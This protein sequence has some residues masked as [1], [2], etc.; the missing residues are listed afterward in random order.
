MLVQPSTLLCCRARAQFAATQDTERQKLLLQCVR[1]SFR[2]FF[3]FNAPGVTPVRV[4]AARDATGDDGGPRQRPLPPLPLTGTPRRPLHCAT[5]RALPFRAATHQPRSMNL[6]RW[7]SATLWS[8]WLTRDVVRRRV[9]ALPPAQLM[10]SQLEAWMDAFHVFLTLPDL[11]ALAEKDKDK[12]S[13]VDAVRCAV[14]HNINL[15]RP[16]LPPPDQLP[17]LRSLLR[18]RGVAGGR[19]G[20]CACRC[21]GVS[22]LWCCVWCLDVLP[23]AQYMEQSEE[24]FAKYLKTFV[25]AVWGL[26]LKL[27]PA[28]GQVRT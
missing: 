3:S 25:T 27:S 13:V 14:C 8:A 22:P 1:L 28:A 20:V 15:V 4:W 2:I 17:W 10:E 19:S 12:E 6:K 5:W 11:P 16:P 26:L 7:A 18:L 24:D 9:R 23:C 21:D